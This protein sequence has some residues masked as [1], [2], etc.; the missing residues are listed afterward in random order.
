M[1]PFSKDIIVVILAAG[2]SS[3]MGLKTSKVLFPVAG[4][5]MVC[6][7]LDIA[8]DYAKN[9]VYVV[10]SPEVSEALAAEKVHTIVQQNP[11][12][13][14]HAFALALDEII[15]DIERD[16]E[17]YVPEFTKGDD[18]VSLVSSRLKIDNLI[19]TAQESDVSD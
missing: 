15:V 9:S 13:T 16:R 7:V 4:R 19:D 8:H 18:F 1:N 12:G 5:P 3:R 17:L 11:R 6:G 14:G 10:V 2:K